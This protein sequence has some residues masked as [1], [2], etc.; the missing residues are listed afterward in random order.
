MKKTVRKHAMSKNYEKALFSLANL[1]KRGKFLTTRQI[2]TR[3]RC[4]RIVA[5]R[6]VN[7]LGAVF[8]LRLMEMKVRTGE[9]GPAA[10]A[11]RLPTRAKLWR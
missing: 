2:A 8:D 9:R 10:S 3:M 5:H 11:Y 6:R 4:S 1:L 7:Q